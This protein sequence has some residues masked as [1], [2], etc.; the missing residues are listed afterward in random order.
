LLY[1]AA[2]ASFSELALP[3]TVYNTARIPLECFS[4]ECSEVRLYLL[5]D[6]IANDKIPCSSCGQPIDLG[7]DQ[8]RAAI[9]ETAEYY[10]AII[11]G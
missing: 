11:I 8:W 4:P 3:V 5:R 10:K 1:C 7:S 6:L 2:R 9:E